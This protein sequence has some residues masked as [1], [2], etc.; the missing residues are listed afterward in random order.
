[1][2][3]TFCKSHRH[4][5]RK[6]NP[7]QQ[8]KQMKI[9]N[10]T[11]WVKTFVGSQSYRIKGKSKKHQDQVMPLCLEED[12]DE[13]GLNHRAGSSNEVGELNLKTAVVKK[14]TKTRVNANTLLYGSQGSLLLSL[15]TM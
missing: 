6:G 8:F 1:M 4:I 2:V 15:K 9:L 14:K 12:G 11:S 7:L 3:L 5:S 13:L 10:L